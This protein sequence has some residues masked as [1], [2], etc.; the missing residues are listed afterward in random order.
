M[1]RPLVLRGV[2]KTDAHPLAMQGHC[3]V[4]VALSFRMQALAKHGV[5]NLLLEPTRHKYQTI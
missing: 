2:Q 4:V 3:K 1:V 5:R